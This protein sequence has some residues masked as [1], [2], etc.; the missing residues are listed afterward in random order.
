MDIEERK[1]RRAKDTEKAKNLKDKGNAAM[2][3]GDY[4]KAMEFYTLALE[5]VFSIVFRSKTSNPFTQI[6]PSLS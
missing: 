6:E 2:K 1:A 4:Q 3:E 5:H